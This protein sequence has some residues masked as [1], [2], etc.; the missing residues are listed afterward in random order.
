MAGSQLIGLPIE[1]QESVDGSRLR[2]LTPNRELASST[3]GAV[4]ETSL[5]G[6]KRTAEVNITVGGVIV[7]GGGG[8]MLST[9]VRSTCNGGGNNSCP[10]AIGS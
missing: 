9:D 8:A 2:K 5:V 7:G 10:C 1:L 4:F 3:L 6:A